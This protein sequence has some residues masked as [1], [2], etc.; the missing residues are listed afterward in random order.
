[1]FHEWTWAS[2]IYLQLPRWICTRQKRHCLSQ[3][4]CCVF[5]DTTLPRLDSPSIL[6]LSCAATRTTIWTHRRVFCFFAFLK[7]NDSHLI[8]VVYRSSIWSLSLHA[9]VYLVAVCCKQR[10]YDCSSCYRPYVIDSRSYDGHLMILVQI[11]DTAL[12]QDII[13]IND[14][15]DEPPTCIRTSQ[16][17]Y[18]CYEFLV[19]GQVF[20]GSGL[21]GSSTRFTPNQHLFQSVHWR[22]CPI[23]SILLTW[24]FWELSQTLS[25][26]IIYYNTSR[27]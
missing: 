8:V 20:V 10:S 26:L 17:Y 12:W 27:S 18:C 24:C 1:M 19:L 6:P 9:I 7:L 25:E 16:L 2:S 11:Q 23:S 13:T 15:S 3:T 4:R 21:N 22:W 14:G 5:W